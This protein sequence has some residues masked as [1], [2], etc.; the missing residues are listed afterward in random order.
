MIKYSLL[1]GGGG[2]MGTCLR[3]LAA[4]ASTFLLA[5]LP[6]PAATAGEAIEIGVAP[7]YSIK[8]LFEQY[9]PLRLHLEKSL[10][11][12]VYLATAKDFHDFA[13]ATRR[14]DFPFV[15]TVPHFGRLAQIDSGY[16][17]LAQM[18]AKLQGTFLVRKDSFFTKIT[19]LKGRTL[20]TPDRLAIITFMGEEALVEAGL[21]L[22]QVAR[23]AKPTH[24]AAALSVLN[25][26]TD[27][28]LVW[29][30]TLASMAP[31]IAGQLRA[32]GNTVELPTFI[33]FLAAP[34]VSA[35]DAEAAREAVLAFGA[36]EAGQAFKKATAYGHIAPVL[37]AEIAHLDRY[38]PRVRDALGQR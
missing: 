29:H 16:R 10:A 6:L 15:F 19:D 20:A 32:I 26:E 3:K 35:A 18:K 14:H 9:E 27:A 37:P 36:S 31:E 24:N 23:Q 21:S 12:P 28:A 2:M 1:A 4:A 17:P 25:G 38:L 7:Y 30:S 13:H 8:L 5:L 33:L 34:E 11:R 22:S